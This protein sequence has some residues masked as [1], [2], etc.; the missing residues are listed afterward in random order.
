MMLKL[1]DM[2]VELERRRSSLSRSAQARLA[3][4]AQPEGDVQPKAAKRT[5]ARAQVE[6]QPEACCCPAATT[7]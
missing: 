1:M 7:A 6:A 3:L 5:G 2:T 4:L